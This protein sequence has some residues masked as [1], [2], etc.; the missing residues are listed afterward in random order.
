MKIEL[1]D[2]YKKFDNEIEIL[3][4]I[5]FND[6]FNALAI[7]GPSGDGKST[8]LR[9]LGGLLSYTSGNI[10][11]DNKELGHNDKKLID[12]RRTIGFV[13][14]QGGLF[15]HM[16]AMD[17]IIIPLVKVHGFNN[18]DAKERA[19]ELLDRFGL[20]NDADKK[21]SE[22]SGGQQQR[23]AIARAIASKPKLLLL[24][25]PTSALDPEYTNEVLDMINELKNDGID[26]VIVTHE[27]GF[28]RHACDKIA[29]LIGGR[30]IESGNSVDIFN[31]PKT[32][33]LKNFLDKLLEWK[34]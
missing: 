17:N 29:F 32:I 30:I 1:N 2:L 10:F 33:Q 14:Q 21:P 9:I 11:I 4:G 20:L 31:N 3:K 26:F 5:N 24:D 25:E 27:I 7:I 28:A 13:F 18:I 16:T 8:L 23:I 6:D 19:K 22:L 34:V 15:R 12:Y